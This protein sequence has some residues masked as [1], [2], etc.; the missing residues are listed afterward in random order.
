MNREDRKNIPIY[1]QVIFRRMEDYI[2]SRYCEEKNI[3][4]THLLIL[5]VC[6][7]NIQGIEPSV[8]ADIVVIP[9]Q[10]LTSV[11]NEFEHIGYVERVKHPSDGRKKLVK[12]LPKGEDYIRDVLEELIEKDIQS[13]SYLSPAEQSMYVELYIKLIKAKCKTYGI[14]DLPMMSM[15]NYRIL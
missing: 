4:F 10:T 15:L 1:Q 12:I 3:P 2:Y 9:R 8:L 13:A 14:E 11:L 7:M 6:Y 5:D